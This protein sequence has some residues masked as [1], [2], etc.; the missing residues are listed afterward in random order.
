MPNSSNLLTVILTKRPTRVFYLANE[1][2]SY[3]AGVSY[4]AASKSTSR[5]LILLLLKRGQ[6]CHRGTSN[7]GR[8][9]FTGTTEETRSAI[10]IKGIEIRDANSLQ[11]IG[12]PHT[13]I[14]EPQMSLAINDPG[15]DLSHTSQEHVK[16]NLLTHKCWQWLWQGGSNKL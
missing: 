3:L 1:L 15:N 4:W 7:N 9:D 11:R 14:I 13:Q 12:Q 2:V 6:F 5:P 10:D 8:Q 16:S